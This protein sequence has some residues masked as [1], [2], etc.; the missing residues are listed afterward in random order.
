MLGKV[1]EEL[2]L[3]GN[4][5]CRLLTLWLSHADRAWSHHILEAGCVHVGSLKGMAASERVKRRE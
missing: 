4:W 5:P 3:Q 2:S 1:L